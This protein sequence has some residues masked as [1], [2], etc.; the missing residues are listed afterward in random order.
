MPS[1]DQPPPVSAPPA[2][3]SQPENL[4]ITK[5]YPVFY[6]ASVFAAVACPLALVAPTRGKTPFKNA[7]LGISAFA[8]WNA[9]AEHHTGKSIT[10]RSS[11]RWGAML[12]F[13]SKEEARQREGGDKVE[14]KAELVDGL[15]T[16]R[17]ARNR[18]LMEAEKRRRAEAEGREYKEKD[19]R[20][21]FERLWMGNEKE[22]WKEKRM[23]EERKALESGKGYGELIIEQVKEVWSGKGEGEEKGEEKGKKE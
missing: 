19:R 22:G 9:L 7:V 16:E 15:P 3:T 1:D 4:P 6:Y 21:L 5:Q 18:A 8:G 17:A 23:E 14:K 10:A 2:T 12:G 13:K 20:G 11:E